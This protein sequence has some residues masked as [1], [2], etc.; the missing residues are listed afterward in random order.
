MFRPLARPLARSLGVAAVALFAA[1]PFAAGP[2]VAGAG[3]PAPA[4]PA[5]RPAAALDTAVFAGG[6]FW[7]VEAV[8]EHVRGVSDV[9]S[10]YAGGRAPS[11]SYEQV[12]TGETGHAEAVRVV[13]DPA[14]VSYAQLLQVFFTVA[15]D[16]T[17]LNRQGPD[18]GTQ[19]RSAVFYR[20]PAQKRA[21]ET[22]VAGLR[23][24]RAFARPVVTQ[25]APLAAFHEAEAYHQGYMARHPDQPYIVI[26][27]APKLEQLRSACR[28]CT[29]PDRGR[30]F[31]PRRSTVSSRA[32]RGTC[33][34]G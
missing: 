1:A 20:T 3:T 9:V 10:G 4:A 33:L 8:F 28:R 17:E 32:Q 24:T 16:P 25:L 5:P 23:V 30:A 13:Y 26:H 22:Y 12:S 7:G 11:P 2:A 19:Y 18:V 27:D 31:P 14:T 29:G 6:C 34:H 21:V 15:H